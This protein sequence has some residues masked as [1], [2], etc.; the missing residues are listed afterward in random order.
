MEGNMWIFAT[1]GL[2][3]C[4][5]MPVDSGFAWFKKAIKLSMV[6]DSVDDMYFGCNKQMM[7]K[8]EYKFLPEEKSLNS[9]G[10]HW[11]AVES[12]GK[13]TFVQSEDDDL[14]I[15]HKRAIRVYTGD[16]D[17]VLIPPYETFKITEIN[18]KKTFRDLKDCEVVFVLES[19]GVMSSLNCNAVEKLV[20]TESTFGGTNN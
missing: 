5:M 19:A 20:T 9:F 2:L 14:T 16:E 1:L 17:E 4:W 10:E 13:N 18:R 6:Q 7:S 3:L 12:L 11:R 15:D 8:V